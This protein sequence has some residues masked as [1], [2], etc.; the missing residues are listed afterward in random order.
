VLDVTV[1]IAHGVDS[2]TRTRTL[3]PGDRV[4]AEGEEVCAALAD[5]S[6]G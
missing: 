5:D 4:H 1:E 3:Q 2:P 6:A